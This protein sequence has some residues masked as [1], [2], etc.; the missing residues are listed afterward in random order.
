M[1]DIPDLH[2]AYVT[3]TDATLEAAARTCL[4][5]LSKTQWAPISSAVGVD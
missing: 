3:D 5:T 4:T 2:R 1:R